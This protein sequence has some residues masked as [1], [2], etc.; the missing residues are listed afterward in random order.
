MLSPKMLAKAKAAQQNAR[1][2]AQTDNI[3]ERPQRAPKAAALQRKDWIKQKEGQPVDDAP[4]TAAR[5]PTEVQKRAGSASYGS[6]TNTVDSEAQVLE[7]LTPQASLQAKGRG[8]GCGSTSAVG[9][10]RGVCSVTST[11]EAALRG[12]ANLRG[13]RQGAGRGGRRGQG[14]AE[15]AEQNVT[16]QSLPKTSQHRPVR[17]LNR[18]I[19]DDEDDD[20][21]E[22]DEAFDGTGS[23]EEP[24]ERDDD[25]EEEEE[26]ELN[27]DF[28]Q[29]EMVFIPNEQGNELGDT[30]LMGPSSRATS[31]P[32]SDCQD[33][34]TSNKNVEVEGNVDLNASGFD[35]DFRPNKVSKRDQQFAQEVPQIAAAVEKLMPTQPT[36]SRNWPEHA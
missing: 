23:D 32:S 1:N 2:K 3:E 28:L 34:D 33:E 27:D 13:H 5:L 18:K 19:V 24:E 31:V 29:D 10:A 11:Q 20:T 16:E 22:E 4:S 7:I 35:N 8:R 9:T 30:S 26:D 15:P 25:R 6:L 17:R 21:E 36:P 12:A 14:Q